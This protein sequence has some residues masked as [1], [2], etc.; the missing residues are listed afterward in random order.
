MAKE[1]KATK[2][3]D[4]KD[5][6]IDEDANKGLPVVELPAKLVQ[7]LADE[8]AKNVISRLP[9]M[10][11][12]RSKPKKQKKIENAI[13][14]DTSAIID[15]R[16]FDVISLGVLTGIVIIPES[17]L[18]ELKHIA[19]SQDLVK[20]ER[21]RKGLDLLDKLRKSKKIKVSSSS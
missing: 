7:S 8:V 2:K 9:N 5:K 10:S 4:K 15:G 3:I 11:R 17:I 21:G 13:F 14:L 6:K 12:R 1:V 18:L 16:V 20:R 19:D